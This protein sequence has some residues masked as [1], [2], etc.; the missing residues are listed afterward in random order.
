VETAIAIVLA[1]CREG[2]YLPVPTQSAHDAVGEFT[3][4]LRKRK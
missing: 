3:K 1:C 2:A 4:P